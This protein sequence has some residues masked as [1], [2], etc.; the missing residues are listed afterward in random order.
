MFLKTLQIR[1][2]YDPA[3]SLWGIYPN[4]MKSV[5]QRESYAPM[6]TSAPPTIATVW[7]QPKCPSA[8]EWIKIS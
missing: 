1:L 8:E 3:I 6:F 4:E 2:S 7:K 5:T